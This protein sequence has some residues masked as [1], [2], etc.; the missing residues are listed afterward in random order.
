MVPWGVFIPE[1]ITMDHLIHL[2]SGRKKD[3]P[4]K[5]YRPLSCQVR[6]K[7]KTNLEVFPEVFKPNPHFNLSSIQAF[8]QLL[9]RRL[10]VN[11]QPLIKGL[12]TNS[13]FW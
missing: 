6:S 8:L 7:K 1:R 11:Q 13:S 5:T 10:L 2:S 4:K 3:K 12:S 9:L